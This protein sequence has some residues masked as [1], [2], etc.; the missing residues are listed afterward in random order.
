ML[1]C[2]TCPPINLIVSGYRAVSP[3]WVIGLLDSSM[4]MSILIIWRRAKWL[5]RRVRPCG[6]ELSDPRWVLVSIMSSSRAQHCVNYPTVR[7]NEVWRTLAGWITIRI[8]GSWS[9]ILICAVHCF[10][11]HCVAIIWFHYQLWSL[12]VVVLFGYWFIAA[13]MG[14]VLPQKKYNTPLMPWTGLEL[15]LPYCP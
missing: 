11:N 3:S 8:G 6:V 2:W 4:R 1:C 12:S 15:Y 14:R 13:T 7:G 9:V 10:M 5:F